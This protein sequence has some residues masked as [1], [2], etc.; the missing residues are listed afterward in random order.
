MEYG[1]RET[2]LQS[3]AKLD[4]VYLIL[5]KKANYKVITY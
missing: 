1:S 2:K 5:L 4:K 3:G